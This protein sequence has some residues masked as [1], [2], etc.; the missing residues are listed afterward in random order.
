M[1][2]L[3]LDSLLDAFLDTLRILPFLFL[4]Y[5]AMEWLEHR[6]E[7]P[8]RLAIR[9]GGHIG[10]LIGAALGVVPQCGFSATAS[11][12]FAGGVISLGTLLAVFLSTSDEMLPLLLTA[13]AGIRMIL[14]ILGIKAFYAMA[15]GFLVDLVHRR[16]QPVHMGEEFQMAKLCEEEHCGCDKNLL[17]SALHHT[18]TV[19]AAIFI[20]SL[21]LTVSINVI[22]EE[23]LGGLFQGHRLLAPFLAGVVGLIPNCASSV[24]LT[25]LYLEGLLSADAMLAGL[26]V[27]AGVGLIVLFQTARPIRRNIG[28]TALLYALGVAGGMLM[29]VLPPGVLL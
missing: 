18:V 10:P 26:F 4:T 24:V 2:D 5:L 15:A 6:A 14:A 1:T 21:L 23:A 20:V 16:V 22:G 17:K 29:G 8:M 11:S 27:N 28:I 13:G 12:L 19:T 3:L 9:N 25:E 7:N